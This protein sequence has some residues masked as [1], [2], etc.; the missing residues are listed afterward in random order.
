[1]NS[2][3]LQFFLSSFMLLMACSLFAQDLKY[4]RAYF[5]AFPD[6]RVISSN[7][8]ASHPDQWQN[9]N[10]YI[11]F[12]KRPEGW[13]I[14]KKKY[15]KSDEG[16][17]RKRI[18]DARKQAY[19]FDIAQ[20]HS[21]RKNY[22]A[23]DFEYY[24]YPLYG[25]KESYQQVIDLFGGLDYKELLPS[26]LE[27]LA[28]AYENK[29]HGEFRKQENYALAVYDSSFK[30]NDIPLIT[31][32]EA[33]KNAW[34]SI[35][36][37]QY[38]AKRHP[39][40]LSIVGDMKVKLANSYL[41]HYLVFSGIQQHSI[42][43]NFLQKAKYSK[44]LLAY[45]KNILKSC[46]PNAILI[47]YGDNDS[48]PL[49]YLQEIRN[50]RKD[51]SIMNQMQLM[52]GRYIHYNSQLLP[53]KKNIK[54]SL[55]IQ[56]YIVDRNDY[57]LI[58]QAEEE[59]PSFFNR[60]QQSHNYSDSIQNIQIP[61]SLYLE[62]GKGKIEFTLS[63]SYI[64]KNELAI[65]DIISSNW[66]KRPFCMVPQT[67]S[68]LYNAIRPYLKTVG[69]LE[70]LQS[71]RQENQGNFPSLSYQ[72]TADLFLKV[73]DWPKVSKEEAF[74]QKLLPTASNMLLLYYQMINYKL[75]K[76]DEKEAKKLYRSYSKR[77]IFKKTNNGRIH[78]YLALIA[79]KLDLKK[80]RDQELMAYMQELQNALDKVLKKPTSAY[81]HC[82]PAQS[83]AT[84]H[85]KIT[86]AINFC[87]L[88]DWD[89]W[90]KKYQKAFNH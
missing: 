11:H 45:S 82:F 18:W 89:D 32:E 69:V 48:Y 42:A 64:Y 77:D 85:L 50:F 55:G 67:S 15:G 56:H 28:R 46:P 76:T 41:F 38:L 83:E 12:E 31:I 72:K 6:Y 29:A 70:I 26:E 58:Q 73:F 84:I 63:S 21:P 35:K 14:L 59:L 43:Q 81:E 2:I 16:F 60:I 40:H 61:K 8:Y 87:R 23:G 9:E 78:L 47:T 79:Q 36:V 17:D 66:P 88:Q 39:T 90:V 5:Q 20:N 80:K 4:E 62:N 1:M 71:E 27:A 33:E 7:Y 51:V 53:P 74:Q 25:Y 13:F 30:V 54:M 57:C 24:I 19:L 44:E 52:T 34:K 68:T 22:A 10:Y 37:Y 49:W 86:E 65:L 75:E 3:Q